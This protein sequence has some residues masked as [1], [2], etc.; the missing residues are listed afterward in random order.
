MNIQ[1]TYGVWE[2][3]TVIESLKAVIAM[4]MMIIILTAEMILLLMNMEVVVVFHV[5]RGKVGLVLPP[6][7]S[8]Q[9]EVERVTRRTLP[10][11]PLPKC[12][13]C[14]YPSHSVTKFRSSPSILGN[15]TS[16]SSSMQRFGL[17]GKGF[18]KWLNKISSLYKNWNSTIHKLWKKIILMWSKFIKRQWSG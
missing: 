15:Q 9:G 10:V 11:L 17:T 13:H 16:P 18:S 8:C 4:M 2:S 7:F 14:W 3:A 6:G 12:R 5:E 1:V